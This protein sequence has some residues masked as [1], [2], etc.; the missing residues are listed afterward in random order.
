MNL[1]H[2]RLIV[3]LIVGVFLLASVAACESTQK[4]EQKPRVKKEQKAKKAPPAK[5]EPGPKAEKPKPKPAPSLPPRQKAFVTRVIDGDTFVIATGQR[6][7]LIGINTPE[8][9]QPYYLEAKQKLA[10][11]IENKEVQMEKDVSETDKYGRLLRYVYIDSLFVNA[12]LVK[13]GYAQAFTYPPDVKHADEFVTLEREARAAGKGLWAVRKTPP[14]PPQPHAPTPAL[15][16]IGN[17]N[18]H[19]LHNLE[20]ADCRY[21]VSLMNPANKVSFSNLQEA[22]NQGYQLCAKCY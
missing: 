9:N 5:P 4:V 3:L 1:R 17:K 2:L 8:V 21:Y 14:A 22:Q 20:H 16:L 6:V 19:K 15:Q 11:L 10:S 7:R 18:S 13:E 12:E